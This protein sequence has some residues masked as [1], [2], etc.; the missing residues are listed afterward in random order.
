MNL[1]KEIY[2]H[3]DVF[4]KVTLTQLVLIWPLIWLIQK[5]A[6]SLQL[7]SVLF[8]AGIAGATSVL[9]FIGLSI[10]C[11]VDTYRSYRA[12]KAFEKEYPW[13]KNL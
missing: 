8:G 9:S 13:L 11:V 12:Q 4:Y 3:I 10:M 1:V 7:E 2:T 6:I 5:L